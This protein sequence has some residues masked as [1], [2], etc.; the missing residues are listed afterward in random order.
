MD[1]RAPDLERNLEEFGLFDLP[2]EPDLL[3]AVSFEL[4]R[5]VAPVPWAEVAAVR[6]VLDIEDA[7]YALET[8]PPVLTGSAVVA[9]PSGLGLVT[10]D[11]ARERTGGGDVLVCID[12]SGAETRWGEDEA[13]RLRAMMRLLAAARIAGASSRLLEIGVAYAKEREAFGR[14]IGSYQAVS[15]KL[16][17][18]A[19]LAEGAELLVKKTAWLASRE[20]TGV[21]Q[22]LFGLMVWSNAVDVGREVSRTVHQT[23]GG[24]GATLEYA[25]QLYSRRIRSWALRLGRPGD[26]YREIGRILLDPSRRDAVIGLWHEEK[27]VTIPRWARELDLTAAGQG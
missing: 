13:Q 25:A 26:A 2:A 23:M 5:S 20:D 3:A 17:Q 24:F 22:P 8:D 19:I 12:R 1:G 18:A 7:A 15:H 6:T 9:T 27:G 16:A 14:P 21:P 4:G 11:G 10:T